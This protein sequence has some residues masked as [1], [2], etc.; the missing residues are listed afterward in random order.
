[1]E[2]AAAG[3]TTTIAKAGK[4]V[5]KVVRLDRTDVQAPQRLGFLAGQISV[6]ADCDRMGEAEIE[7]LFT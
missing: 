1:M 4:P 7:Q 2:R 5:A 3:E 6:P